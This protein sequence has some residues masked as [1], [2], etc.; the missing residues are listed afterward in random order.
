MYLPLSV[1]H[2][3]PS[4]SVSQGLLLFFFTFYHHTG[5]KSYIQSI[6]SC[7]N[8][9]KFWSL[10]H[11]NDSFPS[12]P[13]L[14][15]P[16]HTPTPPPQLLQSASLCL[17]STSPERV[18]Q[19]IHWFL[20]PLKRFGAPIDEVTLTLLLSLRFT[21]LVFDEVSNPKQAGED[22]GMGGGD[23]KGECGVVHY[24]LHSCVGI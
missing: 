17:T 6:H 2:F 13:T 12:P 7:I 9:P 4:H 1:S 22:G 15:L 21:G 23:G 18:T 3:F 8:L 10:S 14:S 19:A 11:L 5:V 24:F 20:S 16:T